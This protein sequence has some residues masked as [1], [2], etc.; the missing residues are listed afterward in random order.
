MDNAEF[1][2]ILTVLTLIGLPFAGYALLLCLDMVLI[3]AAGLRKLW[4]MLH[5]S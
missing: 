5:V 4:R 2:L 3:A 1:L